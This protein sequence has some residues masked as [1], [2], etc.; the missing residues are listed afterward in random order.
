MAAA[1][2]TTLSVRL[3]L[4]G[5]FPVRIAL[6]D[7][8][9]RSK[10]N[11]ALLL[12]RLLAGIK[13]G[14]RFSRPTNVSYGSCD[15]ICG[16]LRTTGPHRQADVVDGQRRAAYGANANVRKL[17]RTC[18]RDVTTSATGQKRKPAPLKDDHNS[19]AIFPSLVIVLMLRA[20]PVLAAGILNLEV[21]IPVP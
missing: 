15:P 3:L 18:Q 11:L 19:A 17:G 1:Q 20:V 9:T 14:K 4:P 5:A 12:L 10:P 6:L 8:S 7:T 21:P 13:L 2:R 16:G